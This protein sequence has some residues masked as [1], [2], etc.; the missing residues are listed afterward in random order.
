MRQR[1][2]CASHQPL[3][4]ITHHTANVEAVTSQK[5]CFNH[6]DFGSNTR[7]STSCDET[8]YSSAYDYQIIGRG[9]VLVGGIRVLPLWRMDVVQQ[10]GIV[11]VQRPNM[12]G[13]VHVLGV[14]I[15]QIRLGKTRLQSLVTD[16]VS[17][18]FDSAQK[19]I[20]FD[21]L[22]RLFIDGVISTCCAREKNASL[23][24]HHDC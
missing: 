18:L 23:V 24:D 2:H 9:S 12:L 14:E 13:D 1:T 7:T 19:A 11:F 22:S 6:R 8:T 20:P 10:C 4:S 3:Q 5:I 17:N 21:G 16:R 15:F